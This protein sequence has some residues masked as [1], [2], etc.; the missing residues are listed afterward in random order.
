IAG[1]DAR[2]GAHEDVAG[3]SHLRPLLAVLAGGSMDARRESQNPAGREETRL[4]VFMAIDQVLA[5]LLRVPVFS[6]LKP[7]QITEIA[8]RAQRCAFGSGEAIV[9]AG[10][11]GEAAYLVLSG[12]VGIKT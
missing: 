12:D 6:G 4:G 11:P 2:H 10:E 8:R 7:L 1:L 5:S 9:A 3:T